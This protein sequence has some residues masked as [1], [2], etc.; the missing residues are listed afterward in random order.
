MPHIP[1]ILTT[2]VLC[3]AAM[4]LNSCIVSNIG[5]TI[6]DMGE[7]KT[8]VDTNNPVGGVVYRQ[9][10][11][12]RHFQLI[13]QAPEIVYRGKDGLITDNL[14][15]DCYLGCPELK[16]TGRHLW[17]RVDSRGDYDFLNGPPS[18]EWEKVKAWNIW[19][20][21]A[22]RLRPYKTHE[23]CNKTLLSILAAPF[24]Y[25]IDPVLSVGYT[26]LWYCGEILTLPFWA[27]PWD[28]A[29]PAHVRYS[30]SE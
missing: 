12:Q 15:H 9:K 5:G 16:E 30:V 29:P 28:A 26:T 1:R 23:T 7:E 10:G 17:V 25:A 24:D 14:V 19:R 11:E 2:T 6:R 27:L 13:M 20:T 18:P 4:G 3:L 8:A 22:N 21:P